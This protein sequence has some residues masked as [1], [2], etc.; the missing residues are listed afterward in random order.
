MFIEEMYKIAWGNKE[1]L[2][3]QNQS[4]EIDPIIQRECKLIAKIHS[5]LTGVG[6]IFAYELARELN[7]TSFLADILMIVLV[8]SLLTMITNYLA[9]YLIMKKVHKNG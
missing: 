4:Y 1:K 3:Y 8:L 7:S 2:E 5:V 9:K 6:V